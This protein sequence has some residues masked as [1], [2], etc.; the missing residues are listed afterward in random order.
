MQQSISVTQ[1]RPNHKH[2]NGE[3]ICTFLCLVQNTT[4]N[5]LTIFKQIE[6]L[7]SVSIPKKDLLRYLSFIFIIT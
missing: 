4:A 1:N 5:K 2:E 3:Q 7:N 6:R